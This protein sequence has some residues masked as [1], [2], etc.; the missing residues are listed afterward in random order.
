MTARIDENFLFTDPQE[1]L[2]LEVTKGLPSNIRRSTMEILAKL[3]RKAE[4]DGAR[5]MIKFDPTEPN[6]STWAVRYYPDPDENGNFWAEGD[7][8]AAAIRQLIDELEGFK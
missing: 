2:P 7:T 6:E 4:K 3:H 5:I 1:G 8:L